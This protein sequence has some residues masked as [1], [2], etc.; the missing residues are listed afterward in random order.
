[1]YMWCNFGGVWVWRFGMFCC[2]FIGWVVVSW[3]YFDDCILFFVEVDWYCI[4]GIFGVWFMIV[5]GYDL[6]VD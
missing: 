3:D 2:G 6:L 4:L 1:M 5:W